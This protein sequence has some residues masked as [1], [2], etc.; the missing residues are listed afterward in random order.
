MEAFFAMNTRQIDYLTGEGRRLCQFTT[1]DILAEVMALWAITSPDDS[2]LDPCCG[3][4]NL[5]EKAMDRLLALGATP[6]KAAKQTYGVEISPRTARVANAILL[7]KYGPGI[8]KVLTADFL[9]IKP[10]EIPLFKAIICNPPYKRHQRLGKRYKAEIANVVSQERAVTIPGTSNQYVHFLLHAL[11]FIA[12]K[13]RLVF[14]LPSQYLTNDF[15]K[16]LRDFLGRNL[17]IHHVILFDERLP[18]F[19]NSMSTASLVLVE[20]SIPDPTWTTSFAKLDSVQALSSLLSD[21][22]VDGKAAATVRAVP[23]RA[24]LNAEKWAGF[25]YKP[26]VPQNGKTLADVAEVSRGIATGA[27]EFFFLSDGQAKDKRLPADSL[28]P[29]LVRA[30][31][32]PY[33][34]FGKWDWDRLRRRGKR[35]WMLDCQVEKQ[36]LKN[37]NLSQYIEW[38]EKE[39]FNEGYL[40]SHRNPWYRTENRKPAKILFTYM[41]NGRPRFI[42]NKGRMLTSNAFHSIYPKG[43][44]ASDPTYLKALLAFLN[45]SYTS[46]KLASI[47]R[48]YGGGLLKLEPS[49]TK[50]VPIPD[51]GSFAKINL[52]LLARAFGNLCDEC[53]KSGKWDT[54]EIDRL[55]RKVTEVELG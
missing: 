4:S 42:Y 15:G 52:Q 49:D 51:L 6:R 39:R 31:D 29:I 25:F 34:D 36:S 41:S 32:A 14:L 18:V 3:N 23:Q 27:N 9:K 7:N 24:V 45:S 5:L 46:S 44:F 35:V 22:G 38:G 12:P 17:T 48:T 8:P 2:V 13:G 43:K 33:P 26:T 30:H 54:A 53:R 50:A 37:L 11:S 40:T 10:G 19:L 28:R 16:V 55:L 1:P 47:G 20:N 21:Q